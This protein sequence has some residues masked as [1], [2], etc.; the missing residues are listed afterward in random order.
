MPSV[1]IC[2]HSAT[3]P[4]KGIHRS[5][6]GRGSLLF[7]MRTK[8]HLQANVT[9][10]VNIKSSAEFPSPQIEPDPT[11]MHICT[12]FITIMLRPK[13][14]QYL[15]HCKSSAGYACQSPTY[16]FNECIHKYIEPH[17]VNLILLPFGMSPRDQS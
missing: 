16:H 17:I 14:T 2:I 3:P 13:Q 6:P 5:Q 4:H 12:Q 11:Y 7:Y 9:V 10:H 15:L 1:T 8:E